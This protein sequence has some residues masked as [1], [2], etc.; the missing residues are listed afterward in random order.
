MEKIS[1]T[2]I[3]SETAISIPNWKITPEKEMIINKTSMYNL[4]SMSSSG[5]YLS[6]FF[7]PIGKKRL[8]IGKLFSLKTRPSL[9][10]LI[11]YETYVTG[12]RIY[13][14]ENIEI[15]LD[16]KEYMRDVYQSFI[17]YEIWSGEL[18]Q[19]MWYIQTYYKL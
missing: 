13:G 12:K 7:K 1:N 2:L 3:L 5:Y 10:S 18:A 15:N 9:Y 14:V 19:V 8:G 11:Q 16:I 17:D 6:V 4:C